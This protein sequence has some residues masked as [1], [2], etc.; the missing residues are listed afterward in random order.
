MAL[1][2]LHSL[3]NHRVVDTSVPPDGLGGPQIPTV[4]YRLVGFV[5]GR[6]PE[7]LRY[8]LAGMRSSP[9]QSVV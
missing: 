4:D 7:V 6:I 8:H 5:A 1:K 3:E 9:D 2:L